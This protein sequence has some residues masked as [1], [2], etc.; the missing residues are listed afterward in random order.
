[1]LCER[2]VN[3]GNLY[4]LSKKASFSVVSS[5]IAFIRSASMNPSRSLSPLPP[6]GADIFEVNDMDQE[7][8]VDVTK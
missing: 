4:Y 3:G 1:M 5:K 6:C 2:K 8:A 7:S